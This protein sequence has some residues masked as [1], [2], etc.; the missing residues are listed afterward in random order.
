MSYFTQFQMKANEKG[1]KRETKKAQKEL[2]SKSYRIVPI[3]GNTKK[4]I[5]RC[6]AG[7]HDNIVTLR[8]AK[9]RIQG[10]YPCK[11]CLKDSK[12]HEK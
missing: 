6:V 2:E 9:I 3:Q 10:E 5:L 11:E 8:T 4:I 12:K 7:S 1:K